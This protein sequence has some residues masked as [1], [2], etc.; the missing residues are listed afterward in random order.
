M[1]RVSGDLSDTGWRPLRRTVA[2]S[3]D[4]FRMAFSRLALT[5]ALVMAGDAMVTVALAGSVF[6]DIAPNQ[7]RGKVAL[8]L[9]FTMLPF[10]V[11]APFLGPAIDRSRAGRRVMLVGA[12]A[13]RAVAALLMAR[14]IHSLLLFP[15]ALVL[16]ILSKTHAVTKSSLV[17]AAVRSSDELV[18]ANGKLAMLAAVVGFVAAAPAAAILKL[19][20]GEWVL[21]TAAVLYVAGAAAGLRLR[22]APPAEPVEPAHPDQHAVLQR[23]V[24][25]AA[26]TMAVLRA[27]VGFLTFAVAF[28]FRRHHAPSWWFGLVLSSSLFGNFVGSAIG[29]RLRQ[30]VKEEH[31]LTGAVWLVAL[32]GLVAGRIGS[33]EGFA[34]LGFTVGLSAG[35]GRLAFDAIVQRDAGDA[36]RGRSFARFEATFQLCW[37]GAA[38]VPV[39]VPIPAKASCFV[40]ALGTAMA[41]VSY[42]TGRR[43]LRRSEPARS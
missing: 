18:E 26:T 16:L 24:M 31:I 27:V 34:L 36:V 6:F 40:L 20:G 8:S 43:A 29:S 19:S 11:V 13:G 42:V 14:E 23:G 33:R 22:P 9:L 21:R 38:L 28:D 17:P 39:I 30:R 25:L 41:G 5:H 12:A 35:V 4:P 32:G 1:G 15:A 7:A 37:V 3:D 10:G 2:H